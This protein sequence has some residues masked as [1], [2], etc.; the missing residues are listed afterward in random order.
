MAINDE[1]DRLDRQLSRE[2]DGPVAVVANRAVFAVITTVRRIADQLTRAA[3]DRPFMALL[4]SFEVGYAVARI[5][6]SHA[7]G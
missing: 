2:G 7:R 3:R 1:L 4:I 5:G 6:R